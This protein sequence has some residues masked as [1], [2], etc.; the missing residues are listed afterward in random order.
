MR[1][2]L[3]GASKQR[4]RDV[5]E[6]LAPEYDPELTVGL[7]YNPEMTRDCNRITERYG[8]IYVVVTPAVGT[9]A[10]SHPWQRS[11]LATDLN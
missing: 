11:E 4:I 3:C 2:P 9:I 1:E 5:R 10:G 8:D 6:G 7:T